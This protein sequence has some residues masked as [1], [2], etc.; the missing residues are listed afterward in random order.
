MIWLFLLDC[1]RRGRVDIDL[2]SWLFTESLLRNC[3]DISKRM[4][5][6]KGKRIICEFVNQLCGTEVGDVARADSEC[7]CIVGAILVCLI[8]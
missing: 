1:Q 5:D 4:A 3:F 7:E 8:F 6:K 2:L